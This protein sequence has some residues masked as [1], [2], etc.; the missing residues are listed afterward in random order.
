MSSSSL[1]M[2]VDIL[3]CILN[4]L[5]VYVRFRIAV[6]MRLIHVRNRCLRQMHETRP[7]AASANGHIE[8]LEW[9]HLN[10]PARLTPKII[11]RCLINASCHG[12][13]NVLD[14]LLA[15]S[16]ASKQPLTYDERPLDMAA[17]ERVLDWWQASGLPLKWSTLALDRAAWHDRIDILRWWK[18]S[19]LSLKSQYPLDNIYIGSI[20]NH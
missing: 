3:V 19:G 16:I 13:V 12:C 7:Q 6:N 15:R 2:P 1:V 8:L 18:N 10:E 9:W 20:V 5:D 14:W 11:A 17:N 4:Q